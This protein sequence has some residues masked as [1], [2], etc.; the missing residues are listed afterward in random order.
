MKISDA[1]KLAL[2]GVKKY[3]DDA[4]NENGFSGDYNDLVNR[5]CY[6]DGNGPTLT[7][8]V[9][10]PGTKEIII[11]NGGMSYGFE[12]DLPLPADIGNPVSL[13][14]TVRKSGTTVK[15]VNNIT[16]S[17]NSPGIYTVPS[18]SGYPLA[19][20]ILEDGLSIGNVSVKKGIYVAS[21]AYGSEYVKSITYTVNNSILKQLDEKFIPDTIATK[22]YVDDAVAENGFSGDYNDLTNKP[23]IP[24]VTN[25]LT[26]TLK[27]NY[28]TAY[29]HSQSAHAPSD[30]QKNSDITKAEIEN[31][32]I[33]NIESHTHNQYLTEHQS[34][35]GYAKTSDLHNHNNKSVLD[36]ITANDISY[37]NN[38]SNFDGSYN[39]LTNKPTIPS[40][41]SFAS[42]QYVDGAISDLVD[43]APDALNTLNEL[44]EAIND[45][46]DVYDA[47][48][49]EM[50]TA[51][52]NKANSTQLGGLTLMALSQ[53]EYD[54]LPSK[55]ANTLYL[56][57]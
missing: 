12:S 9:T 51:L 35:E 7:T 18:Q 6:E 31:K 39:S 50:S 10:D 37:W 16:P 43:S 42:K 23:T 21:Q 34:L 13:T 24:T 48:V 20:I 29:N 26:D 52:S 28:D 25:D 22:K 1:L 4:I 2:Q 46:Q 30:A 57:K 5:P 38:K 17:L 55:D 14:F 47:Y 45:H 27:S 49:S 3:V 32:L 8:F 40:V 41:D 44:A 56:I 36:N 53:T 33:G 11:V 19:F 15:E 54:A